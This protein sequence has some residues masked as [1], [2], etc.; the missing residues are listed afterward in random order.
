MTAWNGIGSFFA[1]YVMFFALILLRKKPWG[2]DGENLSSTLRASMCGIAQNTRPSGKN[3]TRQCGS[4]S[5]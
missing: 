1:A 5:R 2:K 3:S 4:L